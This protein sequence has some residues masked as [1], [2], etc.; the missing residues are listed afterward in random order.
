VDKNALERAVL[1]GRN[2]FMC[3]VELSKDSFMKSTR[4][5]LILSN[6]N[7][8]G[9]VIASNPNVLE[10]LDDSEI[11]KF[12]YLVTTEMSLEA[13]EAKAINEFMVISIEK[14]AEN[15]KS[16]ADSVEQVSVS[17]ENVGNSIKGLAGNAE[18]LKGSVEESSAAV[19]EIVASIT[20]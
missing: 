5:C 6:L 20:T 9:E 15:S 17:I 7:E 1:N 11:N 14:V 8:I 3:K 18:S 13:L 4:A 12:E 2:C 10:L 19:Q 16:T